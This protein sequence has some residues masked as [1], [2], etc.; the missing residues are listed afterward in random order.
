MYHVTELVF[1]KYITIVLL[2]MLVLLIIVLIPK[3]ING[4][5]KHELCIDED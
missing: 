1:Y 4:I 5:L 3:T 2:V